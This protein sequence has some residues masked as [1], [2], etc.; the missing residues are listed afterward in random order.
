MSENIFK[1]V[2]PYRSKIAMKLLE[3]ERIVKLLY[4]IEINDEINNLPMPENPYDL[5]KTKIFSRTN[6]DGV[7][8]IEDCYIMLG[9]PLFSPNKKAPNN[10][11]DT[12]MVFTIMCHKKVIDAFEGDRIDLIIGE[13]YDLFN[14]NRD[15]GFRIGSPVIQEGVHKDYFIMTVGFNLTD[16]TEIG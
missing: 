15:F 13:L 10:Y 9:F 8:E 12:K 14:D 11:M 4:Y 2:S 1:K 16:F 7:T 6:V 3:N 5:Y